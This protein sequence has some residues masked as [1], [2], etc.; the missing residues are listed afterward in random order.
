MTQKFGPEDIAE[1]RQGIV[2]A[3]TGVFLRYGYAR[4]TMGDVASAAGLARPALYALFARK[5]DIFAAVVK[6]MNDRKMAEIRKANES[7]RSFERKLHRCCEA[8]GSHGVELMDAY[9]DARDLFDISRPAVQAIYDDFISFLT[10][11]LAEGL[12]DSRLRAKPSQIARNLAFAMRGFKDAAS[13]GAEM[14][15]MIALEVDTLL[16]TQGH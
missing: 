13:D 8:W 6:D 12:T 2:A 3:A 15:K 4:T 11:L 16:A 7:L 5:D 10:E 1:R 14:R 9:P